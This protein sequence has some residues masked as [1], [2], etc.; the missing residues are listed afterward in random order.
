MRDAKSPATPGIELPWRIQML[1]LRGLKPAHRNARTHSKKQVQQL[2]HAI[3]RF[4]VISPLIVDDRGRLLAGHA[5]LEAV[6][7]LG[8]K[9]V[10]VISV[11]QLSE[12]EIRAYM[13]ADNKLA[14]K[15]GWDRE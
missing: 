4:Q 2:A 15:A 6:K 1:P 7:L 3:K 11:S 5:R 9:H 13:L 8:L 14:E 12:T 10:P